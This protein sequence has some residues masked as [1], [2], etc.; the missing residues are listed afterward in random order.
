M[1]LGLVVSLL[2][3]QAVYQWVDGQGQ[4]HFTNVAE[5]IP[6]GVQ[7]RELTFGERVPLVRPSETGARAPEARP[8]ET[9]GRASETR[10]S[11]STARPAEAPAPSPVQRDGCELAQEQ[12]DALEQQLA[13]GEE[14]AQAEEARQAE[15]CQQALNTLGEG[16]WLRCRAGIAAP[17]VS[18]IK[19]QLDAARDGLRRAQAGGC[20]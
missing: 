3:S 11:E 18:P 5:S 13:E 12:V 6:A 8:S 7:R 17:S 14:S 9:A 2:A 15:A 4:A 1:M 16:A 10:T 19:E 20:R